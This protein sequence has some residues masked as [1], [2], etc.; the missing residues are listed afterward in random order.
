MIGLQTKRAATIDIGSNSIRLVIYD[1]LGASILPTFNEK[2][3]AGLGKG[4]A[5]T[6]SLSEKG[7]VA[8]IDALGRFYAILKALGLEDFS[9]VA[10]AAVREASDGVEWC[11]Q[12]E[13]VL[14]RSIRILSGEDEA[15]VSALGVQTS[16]FEA[17][18]VV[19]DLGGSS[20]EFK[21]IGADAPRGESHLLGPLSLAGLLPDIDRVRAVV[22]ET[23]AHSTALQK[24]RG[25]FYAVGGAWRSLARLS[26]SLD[27]YPLR[28]LQGYELTREQVKDVT[29]LCLE[30]VS[31]DAARKQVQAVAKRRAASLPIASIVLEEVIRAGKF[32]R[33]I[34]SSSGLREGVL[35]DLTGAA[36]LDPLVDGVIAF[37]RLDREQIAFGQALVEFAAPVF[38]GQEPMF[39]TAVNDARIIEAACMMADSAGRFHPDHRANMAYDQALRAPYAG[40]RHEERAFIAYAIGRR[41]AKDFKRPSEYSRLS[42]AVQTARAKQLGG[43]M[44]LGAVFSGRSGPILKRAKLDR[45]GDSLRLS[46]CQD[47]K[48]LISETV[49]RRL[50]QAAI[51]MDLKSLVA[52]SDD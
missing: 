24:P 33:I 35:V 25:D 32:E 10:T 20:V 8:A 19:G 14:G 23:L 49:R 18:G 6:G 43:V 38:E 16:V 9:A 42:N 4:L 31:D 30:S 28:V 45:V 37:A 40:L 11:K 3:M 2:V 15:R 27:A 48:A 44:R 17:E 1:V 34:V 26:M 7:K 51:T 36:I 39:G 29:Q 50:E 5:E 46:V 52:L 12:A 47:D 22:R 21:C 13:Q 41:Y